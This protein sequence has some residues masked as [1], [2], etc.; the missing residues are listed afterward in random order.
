MVF[1]TIHHMVFVKVLYRSG[2]RVLTQENHLLRLTMIQ[3]SVMVLE[4]KTIREEK[5]VLVIDR[6]FVTEA[7]QDAILTLS[8]I[9][10]ENQM[11]VIGNAMGI[12]GIPLKDRV[13]WR[14]ETDS[15]KTDL[16]KNGLVVIDLVITKGTENMKKRENVIM[17]E[18]HP[19]KK[20]VGHLNVIVTHAISGEAN[21][22]V[23]L[24]IETAME[25]EIRKKRDFGIKR[26]PKELKST[27]KRKR[28]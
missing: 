21:L 9:D 20:F 24:V 15:V 23:A 6:G 13:I 19:R 17:K 5:C 11:V 12:L 7:L 3:L 16:V 18:L 10:I 2:R 4:M 8:R 26:L 1:E 28:N 27:K 14:K 22:E 25:S